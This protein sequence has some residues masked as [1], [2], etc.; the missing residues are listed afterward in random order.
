MPTCFE[1]DAHSASPSTRFAG[2]VSATNCS[3]DRRDAAILLIATDSPFGIAASTA[4]V[5]VP[6]GR[7][8]R[9][10]D[11]ESGGCSSLEI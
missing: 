4:A 7:D 9:C 11:Q 6:P 5:M 1:R 3:L 2:L 10:A 8:Q